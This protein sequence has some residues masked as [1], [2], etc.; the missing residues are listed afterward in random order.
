MAGYRY[1]ILGDAD[2]TIDGAL[3]GSILIEG[4]LK[5]IL[6]IGFGWQAV[7]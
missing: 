6:V 4:D 1:G 2:D 3:F 5:V 7:D